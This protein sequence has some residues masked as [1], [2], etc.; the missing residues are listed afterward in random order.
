M[1]GDMA[2]KRAKKNAH[3]NS[4]GQRKWSAG[5]K[6]ESTYPPK[7]LFDKDAETIARELASRKVSPK[8]P[9]SG[10]RMLTFYVNRAG[11]NLPASRK[12]ELEHAK[13]LLHERVE[14][15]KKRAAPLRG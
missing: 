15:S 10:M 7:G 3:A 6:T 9:G 14:A 1:E 12:K 8:G 2:E 11:K 4:H 13:E 5:V